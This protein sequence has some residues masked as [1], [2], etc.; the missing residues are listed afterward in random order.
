[1]RGLVVCEETM[2][3]EQ[4]A[5]VCHEANRAYCR[6]LGDWTQQTWESADQW[7]RDSAILGVRFALDNPDAPASAQHDAWLADKL[8]NGWKYGSSKNA[9]LREHPCCV[10]YDKLP[11]E[12]QRKDALFKAIVSALKP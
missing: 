1:M 4:I 6:L 9:N 3:T 5:V 8:S 12:Q 11:P 10:A 2:N 7:Q